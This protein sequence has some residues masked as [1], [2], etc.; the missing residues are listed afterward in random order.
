[1]IE[2]GDL[3]PAP[4]HHLITHQ[5]GTGLN[6]TRMTRA[7]QHT[8]AETPTDPS[9]ILGWI[10]EEAQDQELHQNLCHILTVDQ[11]PDLVPSQGAKEQHQSH[12]EKVS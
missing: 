10:L 1:M 2:K 6:L 3:D 5:R 7:L 9:L 4:H 11:S 12:Q 8:P